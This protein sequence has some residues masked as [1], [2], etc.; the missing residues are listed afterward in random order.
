MKNKQKIQKNH[1]FDV[2]DA[3]DVPAVLKPSF[4]DRKMPGIDSGDSS[5]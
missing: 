2:F 5:T 1:H 4:S 3:F